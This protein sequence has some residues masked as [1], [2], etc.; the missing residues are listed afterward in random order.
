MPLK[1]K[2]GRLPEDQKE[3][4]TM[5]ETDSFGPVRVLILDNPPVNAVSP[6]VPRALM[7]ALREAEAD[8]GVAGILLA[9]GGKGGF[10]GADIRFQ[11]GAWPE[12]EPKL[13]DLITVLDGA[14]KPTLALVRGNALGGGLEMAMACLFRAATPGTKLGQ[15][16]VN[17]GIPPGAG[18]TQRLPRLVG[19]EKALDMIVGG[20]PIPA[21]AGL[22]C[23]LI[24]VIVPEADNPIEAAASWFA[25]RLKADALPPPV[26]RRVVPEFSAG[27][28][29]EARASAA[30]RSRGQSAPLICVDCVEAA[31]RLPFTEGA[32]FERERFHKAVGSP[33]AAA[34]RHVFAAERAA[35]KV[36]GLDPAC[37]VRVARVGIVGAGTMGTG[38]AMACANAGLDVMVSDRGEEMLDRARTRVSETYAGQARKGRI[39]DAEAGR[40]RDRIGFGV[41][42]EVL[43][44]C[45]LVIEAAFEDMDVKRAIFADLARLTKRG[46]VLAT[47]TSYLDIDRIAEAAG[48]RRADVV[49]LHFFSPANIMPLLEVV[50]AEATSDAALATA[51]ETG[52]RLR[53][54]AIVARVCPGF[55]ANRTFE[56]YTREA[57]FLLQEGATPEQVDAAL[58][59]FGM[60]MGPFAVRDLAGL[61]IGWARRKSVAHERDPALR[62]SRVGDL[63]CERGWFGQKTGKGFY[64]YD[65]GSR[66]RRPNP[67]VAEIIRQT[68]AEDGIAQR[69]ITDAEIVERCFYQVVNEAARILDEGIALRASDIDLAWIAGYGFPRWR[70]GVLYWAEGFGLD[71]VLERVRHFDASH[72]YWTPA[73]LLE[74]LAEAGESFATVAAEKSS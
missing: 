52:K 7:A 12:G 60:P 18:G 55:I 24:D 39:D 37:A 46:T 8:S 74:R 73:P 16:E 35:R 43:S 3:T 72:D 15:P 4:N 19:V 13:S 11:G 54:T 50:R 58:V 64:V 2:A 32:A 6:G 26:S 47:N 59:A 30:K 27:I 53:K 67:D 63:I 66:N 29:D 44:G 70:G 22:D 36:P 42:A 71:A 25:E 51:V 38:I 33:H 45:D 5:V 14:A 49:G 68:A 28:F 57:E 34:L 56:K 40:R 62:Y 48:D 69:E 23:G 20:R 61:D 17:L 21:E 41:G 65:E 31:T 10:A 9:A 1:A